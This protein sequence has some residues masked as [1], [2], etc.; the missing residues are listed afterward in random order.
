MAAEGASEPRGCELLFANGGGAGAAVS[1]LIQASQKVHV[2]AREHLALEQV[3]LLRY[4][5]LRKRFYDAVKDAA[6]YK[7]QYARAEKCLNRFL[8]SRDGAEFTREMRTSGVDD[9][10]AATV[11]ADTAQ[12]LDAVTALSLDDVADDLG[13]D[14]PELIVDG[15]SAAALAEKGAV[16]TLRLGMRNAVPLS[17]PAPIWTRLRRRFGH[18]YGGRL[19]EQGER[20]EAKVKAACDAA[21]PDVTAWMRLK[22]LNLT[23]GRGVHAHQMQLRHFFSQIFHRF[24]LL[25]LF[26]F[27]LLLVVVFSL[28]VTLTH[29]QPLSQVDCRTPCQQR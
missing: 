14:L 10:R 12:A 26:F 1:S 17:V 28:P 21:F 5:A 22:Y 15:D 19:R 2:L 29:K 18:F 27:F 23:A 9:E 16:V 7:A 11:A 13:G 8:I 6:G 25:S 4:K 20:D 24:S 3:R